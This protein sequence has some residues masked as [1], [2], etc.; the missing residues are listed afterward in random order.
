MTMGANGMWKA[1]VISAG[2]AAAAQPI[3]EA[4]HASAVRCSNGRVAAVHAVGRCFRRLIPTQEAALAILAAG[5][6]LF[7]CGGHSFSLA[8]AGGLRGSGR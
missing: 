3:H 2:L 4:G 7:C 5:E 1:V 8:D 6:L